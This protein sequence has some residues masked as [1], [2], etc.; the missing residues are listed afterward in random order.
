M[1]LLC[2]GGLVVAE[3]LVFFGTR[4]ALRANLDG[5]LLSIAHAESASMTDRPDGAVHVHNAGTLASEAGT[6]PGYEHFVQIKDADLRVL[7][8]TSNI[9]ARTDFPQNPVLERRALSGQS[10]FA[11]IDNTSERYR[12]VYYPLDT[13]ASGRVVVVVAVATKP[14]IRS[15]EALLATLVGALLVGSAAAVW[16]AARLSAYLTRPLE[17]ITKAARSIDEATLGARIPDVSPDRELRELSDILNEM[18]GRLETAFHAQQRNVEA[19]KRFM[20]DASHEVRTPLANMRGT[21]EVTLR[22]PRTAEEYREALET[23]LPEIVRLSSLVSDLLTLSRVE[24]GRLA[25]SFTPC[26][27]A[28]IVH[29]VAASFSA[30]ATA[31]GVALRVEAHEPVLVRG[32]HG[33][34]QQVVTNLLDNAIRHT[35]AASVV[36]VAVRRGPRGAEVSVSDQGV[37]LSPEDRGRIFERFYRVDGARTRESGGVGLGLAIVKAI[38]EAHGGEVWVD[39]E[40]GRG[41]T[42]SVHLPAQTTG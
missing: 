18:L 36:V 20:A 33:Q 31:K 41:A 21:V 34:L 17:R 25:E 24:G 28:E 32:S 16:G 38:V 19:Q 15:L 1:A 29:V 30:R 39:S 22:R 14:V 11:D 6:G 42:F 40:P 26:D 23:L 5:A 9:T 7:A 3:A 10:F 12:A 37:G 8:Q 2:V 4:Q 13:T 35:P 27:L